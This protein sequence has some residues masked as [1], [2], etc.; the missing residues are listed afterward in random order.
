MIFINVLKQDIKKRETLEN[1]YI[2]VQKYLRLI[3][4]MAWIGRD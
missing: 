2:Q 3:S 1:L 4:L